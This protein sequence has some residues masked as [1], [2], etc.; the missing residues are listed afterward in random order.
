[1]HLVCSHEAAERKVYIL[2]SVLMYLANPIRCSG[3]IEVL[4]RIEAL[5]VILANLG[6]N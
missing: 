5:Q 1:M 3:G 6:R 2:P 4:M